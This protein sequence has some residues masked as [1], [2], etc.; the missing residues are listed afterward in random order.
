MLISFQRLLILGFALF[1][2]ACA[3]PPPAE[4]AI[5]GYSVNSTRVAVHRNAGRGGA[6]ALGDVDTH[7]NLLNSY[8]KKLAAALPGKTGFDRGT[9]AAQ[10]IVNV[11]QLNIPTGAG[12]VLLAGD[13]WVYA[14]FLLKDRASGQIVDRLDNVRV[15]SRG[16]KNLTTFNGLP[17]GA[18]LST[19]ANASASGDPQQVVDRLVEGTVA[20]AV[21]WLRTGD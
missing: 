16:S 1:A 10:L 18:L 8:E 4:K 17:I 5:A 21:I 20:K 2:A 15:E 14:D 11:R 6:P 19:V 13:S 3:A 9:K 7:S 12:R